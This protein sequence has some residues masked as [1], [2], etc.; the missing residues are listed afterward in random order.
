MAQRL[1]SPAR[2]KIGLSQEEPIGEDPRISSSPNDGPTLDALPP[3]TSHAQNLEDVMLRRALQDVGTGFYVD[4]GAYHPAADSVTKW[5]YDSGWSGVNVEPVPDLLAAFE[6]QRPRDINLGVAV[7]GTHRTAT[8]KLQ[9]GTGLS[10]VV[11]DPAAADLSVEVVP[12]DVLLDKHTA[13][14]KIDF[15]K[16]DIE[17]LEGEAINAASLPNRPRIIV[18]EATAP[19]S[20][21]GVWAEWEP[22]LIDLGYD[23]VWYDGLNRFYLDRAEGWRRKYFAAPPNV[24]DNF[25]TLAFGLERPGSLAAQTSHRAVEL[26]RRNAELTSQLEAAA[27]SA[28]A[29]R[30]HIE[31]LLGSSSWNMTQPLREIAKLLWKRP[32]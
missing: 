30:G 4:L 22:H 20:Q 3:M 27:A 5:F 17:G 24:F 28:D 8:L 29:T 19:N 12:L 9:P 16:I 2:R 21:V 14:R 23:F 6:V 1:P 13:G 25:E 15:L 26:A 11:A 31:A 18:V 7:G 10:H 32:G